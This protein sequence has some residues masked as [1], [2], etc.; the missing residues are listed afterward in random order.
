MPTGAK[1]IIFNKKERI[2]SD[3]HNRQAKLN[4]LSI[5][6]MFRLMANVHGD[7]EDSFD[8]TVPNTTE[9]PLRAEI[10]NGLL[11][12]PQIGNFNVLIDPGVI[13]IMAP[14]AVVDES[15]Y[16]L[17]HDIG[18]STPLVIGANASGS[19]RVDVIECQID[20]VATTE[21]ESRDV[22]NDVTGLFSATSLTKTYIAKLTY[23]IRQGTPGS[24][25]PANQSGWL[26]L[27]I[28]SVPSGA[29]SNNDVTFWDVRPMLSDRVYQPYGLTR[30][31]STYETAN[32][33]L[34]DRDFASEV[35]LFGL[36]RGVHKG[37]R[38]G[39]YLRRGSVGTNQNYVDLLLAANQ[40]NGGIGTST[41]VKFVY[42]AFPAGLPRWA[43]YTD[44]ASGSRIP[45]APKGIVIL[46][47]T[48][49]GYH[50]RNTGTITLPTTMGLGNIVVAIG[51]A[52]C[53][54]A[55]Y[56]SSSTLRGGI[57]D[58]RVFWC[59]TANASPGAEGIL[60]NVQGGATV[61]TMLWAPTPST[62][63]PANAKALWAQFVATL[64]FPNSAEY[65]QQTAYLEILSPG[66]QSFAVVGTLYNHFINTSG[67][68]RSLPINTGLVRVPLHFPNT[69]YPIS[70]NPDPTNIRWQHQWTSG[71][72]SAIVGTPTMRIHGWE[73]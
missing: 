4:Q 63:Y 6:E 7:D 59:R 41:G 10:F 38:V 28:A 36:F 54:A 2:A 18:V 19:I 1:R 33:Q 46:A 35:R 56:M 3:D 68:A 13:G 64:T 39:G 14:D 8:L 11:V 22:F 34:N 69:T 40:Q 24:G 58:G 20:S 16:K 66:G 44:S 47:N 43:R 23:R 5:A 73:F 37:R 30:D 62:D 42:L 17:V 29:A 48:G 45:R 65:V 61:N 12:R 21:S 31:L 15:N 9:T 57:H 25:L 70:A 67:A 27:C 51:D 49:P 50:G 60:V 52:M 72:P 71:T 26:P 32:M 55:S 53:I